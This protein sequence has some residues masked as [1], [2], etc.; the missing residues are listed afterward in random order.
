MPKLPL[1]TRQGVQTWVGHNQSIITPSAPAIVGAATYPFRFALSDEERGTRDF[2]NLYLCVDH[3]KRWK[4]VAA[5]R[6][7]NVYAS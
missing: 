7:W 6:P 1:K 2:R 5:G 3:F 4:L